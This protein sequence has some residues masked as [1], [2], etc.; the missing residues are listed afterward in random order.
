V[1]HNFIISPD[2]ILTFYEGWNDYAMN[3]WIAS[4]IQLKYSYINQNRLASIYVGK[5]VH[6]QDVDTK[7]V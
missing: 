5:V 4:N 6:Y 1:A 2:P 7:V 3:L